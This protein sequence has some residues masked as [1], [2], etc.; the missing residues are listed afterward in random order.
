MNVTVTF[1]ARLFEF[2]LICAF[3]KRHFTRFHFKIKI[4]KNF[5]AVWNTPT[6]FLSETITVH[7]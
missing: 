3:Q 4:A 6:A 5:N 1:K 2:F 7:K